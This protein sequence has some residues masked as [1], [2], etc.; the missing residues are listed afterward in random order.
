MASQPRQDPIRDKYYKPVE[1]SESAGNI[2]FWVTTGISVA[3]VFIDRQQNEHAYDTLQWSLVATALCSFFVGVAARLYLL[4]RALNARSEDLLSHVFDVPLTNEQTAGY[5]NNAAPPGM[6]RLAATVLENAF[7]SKEI[8]AEMCRFERVRAV[9]AAIVFVGIMRADDLAFPAIAA[10]TVF[11]EQVF[12][13]WLR[14]EWFRIRSEDAYDRVYRLFLNGASDATFAAAAVDG[15][16]FYES[17]KA[18][19]ATTLSDRIFRKRNADLS[20]RWG[21]VQAKLGI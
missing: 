21:E 5:Y 19:A 16:T 15:F 11:G 17:G 3:L 12:M 8:S 20:V 13:R 7:F 14:L 1:L 10:A 4:P 6:R 18:L 9:V 2:L